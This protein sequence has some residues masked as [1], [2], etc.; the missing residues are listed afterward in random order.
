MLVDYMIDV[1]ELLARGADWLRTYRAQGRGGDPLDAPGTQDITADVLRGQ[2]ELAALAAGFSIVGDQSQAEWL[3]DLG[4]DDLV[5][6]GRRRGT[7]ARRAV[8][9][10]RWPG[11]AAS[12]K[13]RRSP[14]RPGSAPI[15]SS[16]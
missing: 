4:V 9:S 3:R 8:T 15:G 13:A 7:T 6:E 12:A 5:A 16:R 10:L 1:D 11:A 2:L 14:T